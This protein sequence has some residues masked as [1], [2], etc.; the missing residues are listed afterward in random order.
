LYINTTS[1]LLTPTRPHASTNEDVVAELT[2][3]VKK[4]AILAG[5]K[6]PTAS[7][8]MNSIGVTTER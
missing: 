3:A 4:G 6:G 1:S 8:A 2:V 7:Y 5:R